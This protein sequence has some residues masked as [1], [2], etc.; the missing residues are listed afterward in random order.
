MDGNKHL[1]QHPDVMGDLTASIVEADPEMADILDRERIR[2]CDTLELIA[3]ENIV[4]QAVRDALGHAIANKT[5]EG[6]P[7]RR[8]HGGAEIVDLAESLA[9]ERAK[10]LFDCTYANVQPHSGSQANHAV[11]LA[12]LQPGDRIL[13]MQLSAGGHLSHGA[14]ANL[15]GK[16][17]EVHHYGV[18]PENG[19]IDYDEVSQAAERIRPK[20]IIAGG[21]AYPR[22]IDFTPFRESA[23]AVGA[24]FLC[25]MAHF[26]GLVAAGVCESPLPHADVVTCTTTKTLRGP[27]GGVILSR[28]ASLS[29]RLDSAVFPGLQ[30]SA[31]LQVIAAKA[32]CFAEALQ[33]SFKRY[34]AQ[35]ISNARALADTLSAEGIKL[36]SG[37]TDTHM[38]LLDLSDK[39]LTGA[40][41]EE[42]LGR[43]GVT[44]N[45]N[46]TPLDPAN[47]SRWSGVRLGT[48]AATTRGFTEIDF[49]Q[50]GRLIAVILQNEAGAKDPSVERV[51]AT[52]IMNLCKMH[53]IP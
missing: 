47:P 31:H 50:I 12:F 24:V 11:L 2:Q 4:S 34:G 49:R 30:G 5:V 45:K 17:F 52:E 6:Y 3:S 38:V 44:C 9:I 27:R 41:A 8:Y 43:I 13:S 40:A 21:S 37:G 28:D 18:D 1:L 51:V 7:G 10:T 19:R 20:M 36:W 26:A 16:W 15:S 46:P 42:A 32:V 14:K 33:E 39:G 22:E 25:D 48:A 35:V 23:N 29:S 53:R